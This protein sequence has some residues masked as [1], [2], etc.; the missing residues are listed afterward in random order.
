MRH[1]AIT[2]LG[3]ACLTSATGHAGN[4]EGLQRAH[5]HTR[6]RRG[7]AA[8]ATGPHTRREATERSMTFGKTG[9]G[10]VVM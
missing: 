2:G 6:V 3:N 7:G 8:A 5:T 9:V 1:G 4:R 10:R